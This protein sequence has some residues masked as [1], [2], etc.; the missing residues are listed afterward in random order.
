MKVLSSI[1]LIENSVKTGWKQ[2][3]SDSYILVKKTLFIR[4]LADDNV[5]EATSKGSR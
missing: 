2:V 1:C 5:A 3:S 4:W